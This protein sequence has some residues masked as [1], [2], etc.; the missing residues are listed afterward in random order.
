TLIGERIIASADALTGVAALVRSSHER[1]DGGGY[2]DGLRGGDIPLGSR[3]VSVCDAYDAMTSDR[4]YQAALGPDAAL[5][6]LRR[7]A[8][9]QFDPGVVDAF[10]R[11]AERDGAAVTG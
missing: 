4:P 8:G 2:P 1:W 6:E 10:C 9:G 3:I 7:C 11:V 5:T